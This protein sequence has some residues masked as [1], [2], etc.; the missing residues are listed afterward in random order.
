[1][2]ADKDTSSL[3]TDFIEQAKIFRYM[4]GKALLH[5]EKIALTTPFGEIVVQ[6]CSTCLDWNK[7]G[8]QCPKCSSSWRDDWGR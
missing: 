8:Q 5:G 6:W 1:M 3:L 4:T 7:G 2:M